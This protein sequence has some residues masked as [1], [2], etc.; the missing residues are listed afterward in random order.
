MVN[1]KRYALATAIGVAIILFSHYRLGF[2]WTACIAI[3][4]GV[5]VVYQLDED[6]NELRKLISASK[7]AERQWLYQ[8]VVDPQW[9]RLLSDYG[10][11]KGPDEFR[12]LW[13]KGLKSSLLLRFTVLQSDEVGLPQ[14]VYSDT[15]KSF[16]TNLDFEEEVSA[17][18]IDEPDGVRKKFGLEPARLRWFFKLGGVGGYQFGLTVPAKW[19]ECMRTAEAIGELAN[20]ECDTNHLTGRTELTVA[21]LPREEL[22]IYCHRGELDHDLLSK[23]VEVRDSKLVEYGW[24]RNDNPDAEIKSPWHHL[25]HRYFHVQHRRI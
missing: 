5:W 7:L 13:E 21:T 15:R 2:S 10:L 18:E 4:L 3:A 17:V 16:M 20:T 12:Q 1:G 25:E 6:H 24:K 19:W 9:H 22:D 11:I 14:L 23:Q 8:V